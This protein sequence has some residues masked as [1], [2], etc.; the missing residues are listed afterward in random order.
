MKDRA[1]FILLL[2]TWIIHF[3]LSISSSFQFHFNILSLKLILLTHIFVD[4]FLLAHIWTRLHCTAD[5]RC[6][7]TQNGIYRL[8]SFMTVQ[9]T[10]C[11]ICSY[12]LLM[13]HILTIYISAQTLCNCSLFKLYEFSIYAAWCCNGFLNDLHRNSLGLYFTNEK[14]MKLNDLRPRSLC[15]CKSVSV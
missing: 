9:K 6:R 2:L 5:V 3:Y 1:H 7:P 11:V 12:N 10:F 4:A 14:Q 15:R 13:K 8:S